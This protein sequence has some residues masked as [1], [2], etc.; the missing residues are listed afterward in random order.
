MGNELSIDEL[1]VVNWKLLNLNYTALISGERRRAGIR[2]LAYNVDRVSFAGVLGHGEG[3][4]LFFGVL[5][6]VLRLS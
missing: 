6:A 3:S 2:N 5:N 1:S 4:L